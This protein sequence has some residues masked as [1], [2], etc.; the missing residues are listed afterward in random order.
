M[1]VS[2]KHCAQQRVNCRQKY[3]YSRLA[4]KYNLSESSQHTFTNIS[5]F[6]SFFYDCIR[7]VV[8]HKFSKHSQHTLTNILFSS[9]LLS[10]VSQVVFF[11]HLNL[12]VALDFE[13]RS[14]FRPLPQVNLTL[15]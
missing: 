12:S 13:F 14:D 5:F 2:A 15:F 6:L 4:V 11:T 9:F 3:G 1:T 7:P 8:K 10:A